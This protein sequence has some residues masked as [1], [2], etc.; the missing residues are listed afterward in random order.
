MSMLDQLEG[1]SSSLVPTAG[2]GLANDP[3]NRLPKG[4]ER[5]GAAWGRPC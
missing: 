4:A 5:S 2:C 3:R 1:R